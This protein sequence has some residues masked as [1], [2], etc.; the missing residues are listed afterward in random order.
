MKEYKLVQKFCRS[1]GWNLIFNDIEIATFEY[2]AT[3]V[4]QISNKM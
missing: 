2:I 1:D 4:L 3:P